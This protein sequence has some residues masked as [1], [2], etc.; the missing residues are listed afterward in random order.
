VT[1]N[2]GGID[3]PPDITMFLGVGS[4]DATATFCA[5]HP[6]YVR[7]FPIDGGEIRVRD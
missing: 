7:P 2:G 1:D 3:S 5:D 4:L 6:A